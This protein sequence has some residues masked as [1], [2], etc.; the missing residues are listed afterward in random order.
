MVIRASEQA[1]QLSRKAKIVGLLLATSAAMA[2]PGTAFAQDS[3]GAEDGGEI[4]VTGFRGS[5]EASLRQKRE[6]AAVV[7]VITAEDI[8]KFP[9]KNVADA[10]QRVPGVIIER[11]GGEGKS[12]SV[13][14]LQSDLTLTQLNGNYLASSETNNEASRSFNYVLLPAN[15]LSKA[16]LFKTPE[17]RLD[18]GGIGGTVILHT[19]RPLD[20]PAWS[21]FVTAEGTYADTTR[22]VDPQLSGMLS[23]RDKDE[24]FGILVGATWQKRTNRSLT[25]ET[26]SWQ[27]YDDNAARSGVDINGNPFDPAPAEWWGQSGFNDQNGKHYSG[28]FMPTSVNF[29]IRDE[30]RERL[31]IQGTAQWRPTDNL[32]LTANYFRFELK[33]DYVL[34][35]LKIPEWNIARYAGDGNWAGGRLLDRLTMDPSGTIATGAEFS[36]HPGKT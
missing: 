30:K 33:G 8:S 16:E 36:L 12:V 15:M 20:L 9:D 6:A 2:L 26:E 35:M 29:G 28:F 14:G 21:G 17:A 31:G 1:I 22:K 11:S 4:I 7:E 5:I 18:E 23:W 32:T 25:A 24:R 3:A 27:W 34:N 19:R 13:R 10:L